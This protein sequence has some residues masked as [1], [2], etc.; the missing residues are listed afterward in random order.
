MNYKK[1]VLGLAF[2]LVGIFFTANSQLV[3]TGGIIGIGDTPYSVNFILG[4][5]LIAISM[6]IFIGSSL[7]DR[8]YEKGKSEDYYDPAIKSFRRWLQK[9]KGFK[10]TYGT[11]KREYEK[12]EQKYYKNLGEKGAK[13]GYGDRPLK[14]IEDLYKKIHDGDYKPPRSTHTE[15]LRRKFLDNEASRALNEK[16]IYT[17]RKDLI[18]LS[19]KCGYD[20]MEGAKEGTRV[21]DQKGDVLTVIPEH[22]DCNRNTAKEIMFAL[23]TGE[24]SYRKRK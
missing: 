8:T 6:I 15:K 11:A 20:L 13:E 17:K 10:V 7:E 16:R 12:I 4:I 21:L 3:L 19:N 1:R 2:L 22:P 24:S 9:E 5:C 14:G 18:W 23:A